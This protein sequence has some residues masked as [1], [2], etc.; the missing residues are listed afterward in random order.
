MTMLLE[1][2]HADGFIVSEIDTGRLSRDQG[3]LALG[4]K[5]PAGTVLGLILGTTAPPPQP[6]N[7][8]VGNGTFTTIAVAG[9]AVPGAYVLTL[10]SPT[11]FSLAEPDGTLLAAGAVGTAYNAGGLSFTLNAGGTPF[12]AGD[13]FVIEVGGQYV[14][15]DPTASDGSQTAVAIAL[16]DTD[17]SLVA[18]NIGV[19]ARLAEINATEVVWGPNVTTT[20]Q[21]L[22]ALAQLAQ[23]QII[24]RH[25]EGIATYE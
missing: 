8:N 12:A 20:T 13:G 4:H 9:T 5:V 25:G 7:A 22:T 10:T 1:T 6:L 3:T 11:A 14:A 19:L 24:A 23:K 18:C 15:F 17:A 2:R 21:Q 16:N